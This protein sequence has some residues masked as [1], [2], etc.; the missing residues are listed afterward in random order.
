[1]QAGRR[2]WKDVNREFHK[3]ILGKPEAL[4]ELYETFVS[5][6]PLE[7]GGASGIRKESIIHT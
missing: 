6:K 1:M 5:L 7:K 4:K 3:D 2:Y